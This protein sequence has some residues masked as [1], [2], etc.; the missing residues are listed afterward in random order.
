[1]SWWKV[2]KVAGKVALLSAAGVGEC[3]ALS[4]NIKEAI[5]NSARYRP[6]A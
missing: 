3:R 1:M 4:R 5:G 6:A 2:D